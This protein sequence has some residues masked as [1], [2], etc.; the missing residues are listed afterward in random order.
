MSTNLNGK[1]HPPLI[2]DS[3]VQGPTK[4]E[5]MMGKDSER[6]RVCATIANERQVL[7]IKVVIH[8]RIRIGRC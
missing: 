7:F 8:A 1:S 2:K 5:V 4:N 6:E 3:R